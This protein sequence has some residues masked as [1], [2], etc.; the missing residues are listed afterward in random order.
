MITMLLEQPWSILGVGI[1]AF[2]LAVGGLVATG[3]RGFLAA[4][5]GIAILVAGLMVL[6]WS[7]VTDSEQ[8]EQTLFGIA[9][10]LERNDVDAVVDRISARADRLRREVQ[11]RIRTVH[12]R[13][14]SIKSNLEI[15]VYPKRTPPLAEAKF[16]AV[17]SGDLNNGD[18]QGS[19]PRYFVCKFRK[20]DGQWRLYAYED[21]DPIRRR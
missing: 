21:F 11:S 15:E 10:D 2:A 3:K 1:A 4:A 9:A 13:Q 8:V 7:V 16:N 18:Y 14:V 6:E 17:I 12:I 20:E 5:I 19:Y